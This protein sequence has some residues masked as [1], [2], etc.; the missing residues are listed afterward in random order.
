MLDY[1]KLR[2]NVNDI[3]ASMQKTIGNLGTMAKDAERV[4]NIAKNASIIISDIDRKFE[5]VT[6]LSAIDI[7]FLFLAVAL[8]V[9][10]Q[11][12]FTNFK[13]RPGD[14]EAAKGA[15]NIEKKVLGK[16]TKEARLERMNDTHS[17]YRPSLEEVMFN[18]V[19]FDI[20]AGLSGLGGAFEHRAKTPGHD[21]I[22]GYIFGTANIATSTLTTWDM[23]S[24]HI[25]YGD[26][27]SMLKPMASNNANTLLVFEKTIDRFREEEWEGK[28]ILAVSLFKE[29]MHLKSD[30]NSKVSLPIPLISSISPNF[31]K[32]IAAYGFDIAN[33]A[34]VFKQAAYAALINTIIAMVH[35]LMY[36]YNGAG[37]LSLYEVRTRKILSYSNIIA[38]ASNLIVV[39]I[40]GVAGYKMG[41]PKLVKKA[42]SYLDIGGLMVTI[43]RI[44]TDAKFIEQVK[45]EFLEKEFYNTVMGDDFDF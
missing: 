42:L 43:Y 19:P 25:K 18:P 1:E 6:K 29:I 9:V 35:R 7:S 8:Q 30:V 10:R 3:D 17:W 13:E 5:Q 36:E 4:S 45:Q 12:F 16:E 32:Q 40:M 24:F 31:A 34:T 38:S 33:V 41:Q 26:I 22:L 15:K 23:Q 39:S 20:T 37:N 28:Q 27:G 11:Y 21:A 2:R 14:Q 44:V